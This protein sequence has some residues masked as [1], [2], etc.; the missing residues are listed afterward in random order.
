MEWEP[1][2]YSWYSNYAIG[3]MIQGLALGR[4]T[5]LS[6]LKHPDQL[7]G[8]SSLQINQYQGSYPR[9]EHSLTS[10]QP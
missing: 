9:V 5:D 10:I 8:P 6:V 2:Y 1:E 7:W 3:R 4:A